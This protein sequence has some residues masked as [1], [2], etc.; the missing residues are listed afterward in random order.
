MSGKG[1][2][3]GFIETVGLAAAVAAADA[4]C[5]AANVSLIGREISKGYGYVTVKISGEVG[6]VK[7]GLAAAKAASE[8][9]NRVWSVDLIPRPAAGLGD[10]LVWNRET[11]GADRWRE[12]RAGEEAPQEPAPEPE[13]PEV[14]AEEPPSVPEPEGPAPEEPEDETPVPESPGEPREEPEGTEPEESPEEPEEPEGVEPEAPA[15]EPVGV[16]APRRRGKRR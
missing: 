9:V 6:A 7:A 3:L 15:P 1:N 10:V 4:A 12:E 2:A 13:V 11:R 14:P 5:K 8:R 16:R